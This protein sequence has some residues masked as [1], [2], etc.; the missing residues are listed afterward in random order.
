M[1]QQRSERL[2][3]VLT[4]N[5]ATVQLFDRFN[6]ISETETKNEKSCRTLEEYNL[7]KNMYIGM[8]QSLASAPKR[9]MKAYRVKI[10]CDRP[11]FLWYLFK[12][13]HSTVEN[14]VRTTLAK[15]KNLPSTIE[16]KF[17]GIIDKFV[18]HFMTPKIFTRYTRCSLTQLTPFLTLKFWSI[19]R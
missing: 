11:K 9:E 7:A 6:S 13:Y 3:S 2:V 4:K 18:T 15:I 1:A 16:N 8:W 12:Y 5:S 14:M 17:K 10:G 19:S